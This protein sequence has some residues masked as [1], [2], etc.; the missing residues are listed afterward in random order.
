MGSNCGTVTND[1]VIYPSRIPRISSPQPSQRKDIPV[2]RPWERDPPHSGSE[3]QHYSPIDLKIFKFPIDVL[4][5][6][7][8]LRLDLKEIGELYKMPREP[9]YA[10]KHFSYQEQP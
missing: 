9:E 7:R 8:T 10:Q 1:Q 2:K 4:K 3:K 6:F 5:E